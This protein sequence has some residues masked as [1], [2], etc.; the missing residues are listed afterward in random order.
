MG[1]KSPK[2][3]HKQAVQ[4]QVKVDTVKRA[5]EAAVAAKAVS[6]AVKK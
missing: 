1:D 5:K 6:A 4:K 2:S 3:A